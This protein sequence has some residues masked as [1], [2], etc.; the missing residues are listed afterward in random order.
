ME[1]KWLLCK[2][3]KC[4]RHHHGVRTDWDGVTEVVG[5]P[6][7]KQP[8]HGGKDAELSTIAYRRAVRD[9]PRLLHCLEIV[10]WELTWVALRTS[11]N[12]KQSNIGVLVRGCNLGRSIGDTRHCKYH[13]ALRHK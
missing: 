11:S 9:H 12:S 6:P 4:Y 7:P 5:D 10:E 1:Q 2:S 3:Q 8:A 13:I